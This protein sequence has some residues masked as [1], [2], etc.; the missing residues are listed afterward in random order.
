MNDQT[1]PKNKT[2]LVADDDHFIV[3]AFRAGLQ[4]A[5]YEVLVALDGQE[6]VKLITDHRPDVI[7]LDVIMPT[8][9]GFEVLENI[10]TN[11]DLA[12]IP[13]IM[14]TNLSQQSDRDTAQSYGVVDFFVKTDMS[15]KDV[16][17]RLDRL[18]N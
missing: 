1:S 16:L 6:A 15:F 10:K 3:T 11:G 14:F 4:N 9:N 5:G 17:L 18:L 12:R 7:L 2:V 13:V 8:M